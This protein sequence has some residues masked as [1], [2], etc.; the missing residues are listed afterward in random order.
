MQYT[1]A[2]FAAPVLDPFL[3]L[4]HARRHQ[5]PVTGWF[6]QH[7]FDEVHL[8]DPG[9]AV[10]RWTVTA[11]VAPLTRLRVLQRGPVQLYLLYVL[12]TLLLLFVWQVGL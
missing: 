9:E 3:G 7:A 1:A 11:A 12:V 8:E 2:S 6:P 5:T 10:A 4:L